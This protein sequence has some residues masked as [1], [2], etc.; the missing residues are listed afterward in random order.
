[1]TFNLDHA[2]AVRRMA[3]EEG[4]EDSCGMNDL[5]AYR[6]LLDRDGVPP[7][8]SWGLWGADDEI[9]TLNLLDDARTLA[10]ARLVRHGEV[11]ALTLPM[12]LP[13]ERLAWRGKPVHQILRVGHHAN[14]NRP[15]GT[16]DTGGTFIDRDDVID[17]LWLQGGSQWDGL[18]HVRHPRYG[19]Y[20]GVADSDIHEGPGA[21]LGIDKW[22][23]RAVVGRGVLLDVAGFFGSQGRDYDPAGDTR[24]TV[25]D[26]RATAEWERVEPAPGDIL[27]LHTGWLKALLDAPP[28]R[29]QV[30][31]DFTGQ[32]S[33]GLAPS[34]D[35]VEFLW[36][37]HVAAIAADNAALEVMYP[38]C[39]F[40]LH[41]RLLPLHGTPIGEYWALSELADR[42][43][44]HRRY[45]FFFVSVPFNLRGGIGSPPQAIAI[46]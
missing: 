40:W 44:G 20:N 7:G 31:M 1:M 2:V 37:S 27:L 29:R 43:R 19:N 46:F 17:R 36:D 24:I 32:R 12:H 39:D 25:D 6:E 21:R 8:S 9:G 4:V 28:E 23:R 15:G 14:D 34:E 30:M 5:P 3:L 22:A 42:C 45:E 38:G 33:P 13:E 18:A 26:L 35:M 11:V 41:Q 10:A 16:D